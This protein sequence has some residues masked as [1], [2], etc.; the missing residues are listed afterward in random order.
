MTTPGRRCPR[1][2]G[3]GDAA[4]GVEH[5]A[6]AVR[7]GGVYRG[8]G[9]AFF[10]R[11]GRIEQGLRELTEPAPHRS[12]ASK[13]GAGAKR[14]RAQLGAEVDVRIGPCHG[15]AVVGAGGVQQRLYALDA[16]ALAHQ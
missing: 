15:H 9:C 12:A 6:M 16:G 14:L 8:Q 5:H 2:Q 13:Q 7:S 4:Q 1:G 3:I 10:C 11:Q